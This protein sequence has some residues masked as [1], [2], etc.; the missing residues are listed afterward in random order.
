MAAVCL[1]A[2]FHHRSR[3]RRFTVAALT[4]MGVRPL[5]AFSG[6]VKDP[7]TGLD[8]TESGMNKDCVN[9]KPTSERQLPERVTSPGHAVLLLAN[10]YQT[11][12]D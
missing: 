9:G 10:K 7:D 1:G 6:T 5:V 3:I 4:A 12:F 2:A 8:Y 11:G